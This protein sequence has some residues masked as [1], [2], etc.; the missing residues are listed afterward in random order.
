MQRSSL[1]AGILGELSLPGSD[2]TIVIAPAGQWRAQLP[3]STPSVSGTQFSITHTACPICIDDFSALF[4][5]SMAPA[6]QT[7]E[8]AVHSGRQ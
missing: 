2:G 4:M 6:G 5:G 7:S 1:T 3:H 8:H